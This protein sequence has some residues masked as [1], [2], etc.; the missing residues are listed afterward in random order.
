MCPVWTT[1]A[2]TLFRLPA[3]REIVQARQAGFIYNHAIQL[4]GERLGQE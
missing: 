4:L 1:S 3:Q 2:L